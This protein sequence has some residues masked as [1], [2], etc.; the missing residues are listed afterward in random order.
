L[1]ATFTPLTNAITPGG[2]EASH[3]QSSGGFSAACFAAG[4]V[5]FAGTDCFLARGAEVA[6]G[7]P[8]DASLGATM[9]SITEMT[10]DIETLF[11]EPP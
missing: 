10:S 5:R 4:V 8:A 9:P 1:I 11:I 2:A 7:G 3:P 6:C